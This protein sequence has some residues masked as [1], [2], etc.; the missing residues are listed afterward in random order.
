MEGYDAKIDSVGNI[1][2]ESDKG[3]YKLEREAQKLGQIPSKI[4]REY[5]PVEDFCEKYYPTE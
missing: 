4:K 3:V 1:L 2:V 5:F